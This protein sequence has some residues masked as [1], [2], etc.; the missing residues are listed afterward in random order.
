MPV[1]GT[2]KHKGRS[3]TQSLTVRQYNVAWLQASGFTVKGAACLLC[4]SP[5][6]VQVYQD[7]AYRKLGVSRVAQLTLKF[8][9]V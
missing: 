3:A 4:I 6:T 5:K 8:I 2:S 9:Q 1:M 7:A